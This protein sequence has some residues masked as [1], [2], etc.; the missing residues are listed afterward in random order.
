MKALMKIELERAFKNKWFY[1][2][3]SI[4]LLIVLMDIWQ[5][6]LP[7]RRNIEYWLSE[8]NYNY[9]CPGLYLQWMEIN[10]R[11]P[12]MI[13][14]FIIP[15]LA[16]L[17]YSMS[18]YTDV[19]T[20]Y[21]NNIVTKI[22]K[23][24][25][26]LSKLI[27]QFI[28]GG[29]IA[30]LPLVCSFIV[31]AMILPAIHPV[32]ATGQ[33]PFSKLEVFGDLFFYNPLLFVI[34]LLIIDFIGFGLINCIAYIFADLLDNKYMVALSPFIIYFLQ[35]VVCSMIGRDSMR[36]YLQVVH[37]RVKYLGDILLDFTVLVAVIVIAYMV[38]C[39][40]KDVL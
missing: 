7:F 4:T 36:T 5:N 35:Y 21:M 26:Y 18:I 25:Y 39:K 32:A 14:H 30:I 19:K 37:M 16:A 23:K 6:V 8:S 34:V 27:T 24:K 2:S 1:I 10:L 11:A 12:S 20:H 40:R 9:Q 17:P 15:L 31:T 29:C 33:Y 38:R 13:Y 28:S 22:E 3:A